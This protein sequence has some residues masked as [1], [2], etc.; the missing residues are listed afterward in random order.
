MKIYICD[1]SS[2]DL[3]RL[4]HY[5]KKY[6]QEENLMIEVE[7]FLSAKEM[8]LA[9]NAAKEKPTLLFLDIYMNQIDGIEAAKKLRKAGIKTSILFTTSSMEHAME[10]FQVHADGYLHKPFDYEDFKHAMS[11]VSDQ[12][13]TECKTIEVRIERMNR[14]FKVRDICFAES[15]NHGVLIHCM[16]NV[17]RANITM[18]GL[19]EQLTDEA[20]FLTCGRSYIINFA[21]VQEMDGETFLMKNNETIP[22]PVRIRKQMKELYGQYLHENEEKR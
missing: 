2:S 1:D 19:K 17:Y 21:Y 16:D 14:K 18:E 8:L 11:K 9:H 10:A 12:L 15:D 5:L 22:I 6:A 3:L 20:S 13:Q 7:E 4:Q